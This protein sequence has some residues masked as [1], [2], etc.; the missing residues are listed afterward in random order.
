M[1]E[2]RG[3]TESEY[4][5]MYREMKEAENAHNRMIE[6]RQA[7]ERGESP[8]FVSDEALHAALVID[9]RLDVLNYNV[10]IAPRAGEFYGRKL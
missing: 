8:L 9:A 3:P 5:K 6:Q 1:S 10:A 2:Y 4:Q 7:F